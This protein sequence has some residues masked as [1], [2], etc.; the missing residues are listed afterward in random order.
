MLGSEPQ[1][2]ADL[3]RTTRMVNRAG[4]VSV[5]FA[6]CGF[7]A[8]LVSGIGAGNDALTVLLRAVLAML[9]CQLVGMMA[10]SLI[11]RLVTEEEAR[12]RAANPIPSVPEVA[13]PV[14]RHDV[15]VVDEA[16]DERGTMD[17]R[18]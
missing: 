12:Y 13:P 17:A 15:V 14:R 18:P 2:R 10:G 5:A 4:V 1:L 7:A 3:I 11:N 16:V 9:A 8:A 6:L